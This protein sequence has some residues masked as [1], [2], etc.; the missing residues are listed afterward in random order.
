[1]TGTEL[2]EDQNTQLTNT[3]IKGTQCICK[4]NHSEFVYQPLSLSLVHTHMAKLLS[5]SIL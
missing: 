2:I 1:M 5:I 4:I 3:Q